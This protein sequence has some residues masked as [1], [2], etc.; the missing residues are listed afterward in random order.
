MVEPPA[1]AARE[2]AN[3]LPL[4]ELLQ[5]IA[6]IK[7][8]YIARQQVQP[9]EKTADGKLYTPAAVDLFRILG[10]QLQIVRE[11]STHLMLY[12]IALAVIQVMNDFQAAERQRLGSPA[13]EI[14]LEPLCAIINNNFRC[15]DVA[16]EI[17]CSTLEALPQNY[18]EQVNFEDTCKGFLMVAK[19]D[20]VKEEETRTNREQEAFRHGDVRTSHAVAT[21]FLELCHEAVNKTVRLIVEDPGVQEVLVKLYQEDWLEGKVTEHLVATFADYF[22]DVKMYSEERSFKQFVEAC[23]EQLIVVY[24]DHHIF[25]Q[26]NYIKEETIERMKLDEELLMDIFQYN[27]SVSEV[28]NRVRVLRDLR[29]LASSESRDTFTLVRTNI[30]KHQPVCPGVFASR[31]WFGSPRSFRPLPPECPLMKEF[32]EVEK[33]FAV[34]VIPEVP[35]QEIISKVPHQ[36]V[37]LEV[38]SQVVASKDL[39]ENIG[40]S[41]SQGVKMS[42]L[43]DLLMRQLDPA[44]MTAM[45]E[46]NS[47]LLEELRF[48]HSESS[49]LRIQLNQ[50]TEELRIKLEMSE[51][52][53]EFFK[54]RA[55]EREVLMEQCNALHRREVEMLKEFADHQTSESFQKGQ[56]GGFLTGNLAEA[57]TYSS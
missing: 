19:T 26:K 2:V 18:S 29:E 47:V 44:T 23:L 16:M 21:Q 1:A 37:N 9:P 30:F 25:V 38:P 3:V 50:L 53:A 20:W 11:N 46:P 24:V 56:N 12:R 6:S 5:S 32:V 27:I 39:L 7:T 54:L 51:K 28:K 41:S 57:Q 34:E 10:E 31:G 43:C 35:L 55:E 48:A 13:S 22:E 4:P 52:N 33:E 8:D 36:K 15:Y 49:Q 17:S 40:Q 42:S 14:G 45:I